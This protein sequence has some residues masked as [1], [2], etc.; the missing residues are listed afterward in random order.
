MCYALKRIDADVTPF[1]GGGLGVGVVVGSGFENLLDVV[2]RETGICLEPGGYYA[3]H[4]RTRHR[5]ALH[6]APAVGAAIDGDVACGAGGFIGVVAV[7]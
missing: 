7:E 5:G 4:G 2:G 6:N 3:R 1:L